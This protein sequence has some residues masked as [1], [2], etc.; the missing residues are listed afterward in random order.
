V[1]QRA[2]VF[3]GRILMIGENGEIWASGDGARWSR[4]TGRSAW[5]D[6]FRPTPV[7]F[8]ERLWLVGGVGKRDVWVSED[9]SRWSPMPIDPDWFPRGGVS[10]AVLNGALW[11]LGG[12]SGVS[13][14]S[15]PQDVW[16]IRRGPKPRH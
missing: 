15:N 9:G 16:S 12:K 3:R 14:N 13:E 2:V 11:L 4:V 8:D 6:R 7:V 5:A 1:Q 10:A